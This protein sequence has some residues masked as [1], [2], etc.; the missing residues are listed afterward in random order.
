MAD[1]NNYDH[2]PSEL[3]QDERFMDFV[4]VFF[5]DDLTGDD[6]HAVHDA[7]E[8]ELWNEYGLVFDDYIDWADYGD[9]YDG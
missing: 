4:E 6:W 3:L 8:D 7:L 2:F 5:S 9:W 1:Y